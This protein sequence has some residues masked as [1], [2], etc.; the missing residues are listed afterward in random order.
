MN[1]LSPVPRLLCL[2]TYPQGLVAHIAQPAYGDGAYATFV[3]S[4]CFSH[5]F[6]LCA[7]LEFA[8]VGP[9]VSSQIEEAA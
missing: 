2:A 6:T 1:A 8:P 9:A 7:T 4:G 3:C 5:V